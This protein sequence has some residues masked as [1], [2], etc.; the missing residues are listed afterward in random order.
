MLVQI[1]FGGA[2]PKTMWFATLCSDYICLVTSLLWLRVFVVWF[3]V[4][5]SKT[6]WAVSFVTS[7]RVATSRS[8]AT[9]PLTA[10]AHHALALPI[11]WSIWYTLVTVLRIICTIAL[12]SSASMRLSRHLLWLDFMA[13]VSRLILAL[14]LL[15]HLLLSPFLIPYQIANNDVLLVAFELWIMFHALVLL[16]S[17]FVGVF[18]RI[19]TL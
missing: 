8:I 3:L 19:L 10:W 17:L 4:R 7:L 16:Q 15:L 1:D 5:S 6:S 11:W 12:A 13:V 2:C 14:I 9:A 18:E